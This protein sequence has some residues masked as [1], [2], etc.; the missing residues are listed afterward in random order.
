MELEVANGLNMVR[1]NK[2]AVLVPHACK[3]E[4]ETSQER[5]DVEQ[6]GYFWKRLLFI[7]CITEP[8]M[9]LTHLLVGLNF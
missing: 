7:Q 2:E 4:N 8:K 3:R 9:F 5:G 6:Q 1:G